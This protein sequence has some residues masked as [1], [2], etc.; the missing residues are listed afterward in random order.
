LGESLSLKSGYEEWVQIKIL[1]PPLPL[2]ESLSLKSGYEEWVQI[3]ILIPPLPPWVKGE[4]SITPPSHMSEG[5][6][7]LREILVLR[8]RVNVKKAF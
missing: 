1:I 8:S 7:V 2:G 3:Q 6:S 4:R 5:S